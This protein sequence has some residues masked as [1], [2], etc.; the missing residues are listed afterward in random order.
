MT[1]EADK[2]WN[3]CTRGSFDQE[4]SLWNVLSVSQSLYHY[5]IEANDIKQ[6]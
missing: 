2:M 3:M 4:V 5:Y 6:W 1:T